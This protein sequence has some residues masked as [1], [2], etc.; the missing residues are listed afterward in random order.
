MNISEILEIIEPTLGFLI[1]VLELGW[2]IVKKWYWV[3]LPIILL[4]PALFYWLWWRQEIWNDQQKNMLLE[5]RIPKEILKPMRAM[6]S[7]FSGLWQIHTPANWI[8]K[9]WDGQELLNYSFEI[10]AID[11]TPH[12]FVRCPPESRKI[13]ETHIN[14]QFPE[15][16]IFEVE[17]YTQKVPQDI[18]N[19]NWDL[20]AADYE[21][22]KDNSYPIKTYRDFETEREAKEEK[23][24][25]PMSALLEGMSRLQKGEQIWVQI[26]IKAILESDFP[27]TKKGKEVID[28]LV[29]REA[30]KK[31][32][33]FKEMIDL[34]IYG[35][36]AKEEKRADSLPPEMKLTSGEKDVVAGIERKIGKLGY[37][38]FIRF[39]YLGEKKVFF[40]P[41][42]RLP[43]SYFTNFVTD[44]LNA[45][46]PC[47]P[48]LT[49]VRRKWYD[50]FWFPQRRLYLKKRRSFRRYINRLPYYFPQPGGTFILNVE[51]LATL[52]HFPSKVQSPASLL[53]RVEAKKGEAPLELPVE[54]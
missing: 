6:E 33:F 9:W 34:L 12:F 16:E 3:F 39:I 28:K 31:K 44:N 1:P 50:A 53:P 8:E 46:V 30:P 38:T 5:I 10:A 49:K 17:D 41:N 21:L 54:E 11:G 14:S 2:E 32:S 45:A 18:P 23:R 22:K 35:P 36:P 24:I 42:L 7:V 26:R 13:V 4:R 43:M 48:T 52:Y 19:G 27:W 47:S 51:E 25:D 37:E 29:Y 20:W 15:A 40:K